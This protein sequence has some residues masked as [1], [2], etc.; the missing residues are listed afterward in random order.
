LKMKKDFLF[1]IDF[2]A[3]ISVRPSRPPQARGLCG[4][5]GRRCGPTD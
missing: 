2:W 5:A 4:P 3:E 1:E